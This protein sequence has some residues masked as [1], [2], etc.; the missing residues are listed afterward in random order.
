MFRAAPKQGPNA[1]SGGGGGA[2]APAGGG[3][4]G[5]APP[6]PAAGGG[7]GGGGGAPPPQGSG[8]G[9]PVAP[10]VPAGGGGGGGALP[11]GGEFYEWTETVNGKPETVKVK[12][13][14]LHASFRR[15][16]A[17]NRRFHEFQKEEAE[18]RARREKLEARERGIKEGRPDSFFPEDWTR[19]QRIEWMASQLESDLKDET[20]TLD[21][22]QRQLIERAKKG[23]EAAKKLE[24]L[25]K[26]RQET[27]HRQLVQQVKERKAELYGKALSSFKLPQNDLTLSLMANLEQEARDE[28]WE[29]SPEGLADATHGLATEMFDGF[30]KH[31]YREDGSIDDD[32]AVAML[33]SFPKF[34]RVLHHALLVRHARKQ[35]AAGVSVQQQPVKRTPEEQKPPETTGPRLV[36]SVDE[37]KAYGTK[38][39]RTI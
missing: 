23:D 31:C 17:I 6:P 14:A 21:P 11:P 35:K 4:G 30:V 19:D 22:R 38:G 7:G 33:E 1:G 10:V 12:K 24:A 39:L 18:A 37:A 13:E 15:E 8:Q 20:Q 28:G 36:N 26:E 29:H 16:Q 3:G 5:A 9:T 32:A 2:A 25:E 34:E 27:E